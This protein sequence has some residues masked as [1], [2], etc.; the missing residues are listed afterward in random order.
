MKKT[1]KKSAKLRHAEMVAQEHHN[2]WGILFMLLNA[3]AIAVLYA[4]I[5]TLTKDMSS[6]LVV[7]LY[8]FSI[9]VLIIPWC[10]HGGIKSL[11]TT[12]IW[13]HFSRGCLSICGSLCLFF[14]IKYI[15]LVDIT[16][17]GY[18]EQVILVIVGILYFKEKATST[19]IATI[20]LSF[21]GA[22]LVV[23]PEVIVL[24]EYNLPVLHAVDMS[25]EFNKYYIFVFLSIAFW[26]TNCTVI[27]V[28]GRTEKTKVQLFYVMLISCIVAYPLAFMHWQPTT[29]LGLDIKFPDRHLDFSELGLQAKHIPTLALLALCY[30]IHSIAFFKALKYAELS[31]VIPFD[32]SRLVFAGILGF[33]FFGEIPKDGSYVGYLLIVGAGVYLI[34]AESKRRRKKK[35]QLEKEQMEEAELENA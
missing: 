18:M 8:K 1:A 11:K 14:A 6:S 9:L 10:L 25:R 20:I 23:Y 3:V 33:M 30:F 2:L 31:T 24:N 35:E 17:I 19:K 29:A 13:L 12:R 4:A 22:M 7:F 34:R 15:E 5:K 26:A 28:L 27:K 16:A 21:I 32:Y